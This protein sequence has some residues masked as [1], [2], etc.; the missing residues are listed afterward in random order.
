MQ[1]LAKLLLLLLISLSL[2]YAFAGSLPSGSYQKTCT[3]CFS[4]DHMLTCSCQTT[5]KTFRWSSLTKADDCHGIINNNGTLQ[6]A[7]HRSNQHGNNNHHPQKLPQGGYSQSCNS[8]S[9]HGGT[10]SCQ[11]KNQG[12]ALV[13]TQ[14]KL[15]KGCNIQNINGAL[16]CVNQHHQNLPAGS[17]RQSCNS[18]SLHKGVL[19]CSCKTSSSQMHRTTLKNH[20]HCKDIANI[21]GNLQCTRS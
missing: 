16:Q 11:C 20:N 12:G 17:Y 8:C 7:S 9:I 13:A 1:R 4:I 5:A 6:C 3:T 10:L 15:H 14:L 19:V 18:C 2:S 21:N